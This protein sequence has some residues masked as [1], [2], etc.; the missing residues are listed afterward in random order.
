M[1]AVVMVRVPAVSVVQKL[2]V[3]QVALTDSD[4]LAGSDDA[5]VYSTRMMSAWQ[6]WT[7]SRPGFNVRVTPVASTAKA[8]PV[9]GGVAH[10]RPPEPPAP[11]WPPS[12]PAD[13]PCP[14]VPA[15]T[16]ALPPRPPAPPV[17]T[18]P[19]SPPG[20]PLLWHAVPIS[21]AETRNAARRPD[22]L[23]VWTGS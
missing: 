23:P 7:L 4:V 22:A 2:G 6:T 21:V 18:A 11:A 17:C 19:P 14:V 10:V 13:P 5:V 1:R 9:G 15:S 8:V 20:D 16:P 3:G 12:P